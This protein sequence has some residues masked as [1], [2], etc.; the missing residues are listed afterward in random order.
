M[1][2]AGLAAALGATVDQVENAAYFKKKGII[3][4]LTE[5]KLTPESLEYSIGRLFENGKSYTAVCK[6]LDLRSANER[7]LSYLN[8]Y[9]RHTK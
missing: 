6:K 2:A 1:A 8:K 4:V 3:S 5:D 9:A 7:V